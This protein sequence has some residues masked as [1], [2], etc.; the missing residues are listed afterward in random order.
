MKFFVGILLLFVLN[1]ANAKVVGCGNADFSIYVK[2]HT[3]VDNESV[4]EKITWQKSRQPEVTNFDVV[5][6]QTGIQLWELPSQNGFTFPVGNYVGKDS[7]SGD[8][9]VLTITRETA[10]GGGGFSHFGTMTFLRGDEVFS[11]GMYCT[12]EL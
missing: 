7:E 11:W 1:T 6:S 5:S 2:A 12:E 3:K 4:I 10:F 8:K 9:L